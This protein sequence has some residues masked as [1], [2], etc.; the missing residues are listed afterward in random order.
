MDY[1]KIDQN[2]NSL[3]SMS[4]RKFYRK[5]RNKQLCLENK[6]KDN[7][8]DCDYDTSKQELM[9]KD[10]VTKTTSKKLEIIALW[11]INNLINTYL[12]S[13][14]LPYVL[15]D[16]QFKHI[17]IDG[18]LF[19]LNK[20][21]KL[22]T[23]TTDNKET[24]PDINQI[25]FY[26]F[27]DEFDH[28][29]IKGELPES[30]KLLSFG[31][32]FNQPILPDVLPNS[33]N[34]LIFGHSFNQVIEKGTLP[35]NLTHLVFGHCFNQILAKG[36]LPQKLTHLFFGYSFNQEIYH[37]VL[38]NNLIHL[39]F[40]TSFNK[41]LLEG[42]MPDSLVH[43]SFGKCFNQP[44]NKNL[45]PKNLTHL[46]FR[47]NFNQPNAECVFPCNLCTYIIDHRFKLST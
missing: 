20:S 43:L 26:M 8:Y 38:P 21:N 15:F 6:V 41:L 22:L 7:D 33:I 34:H 30:L 3:K 32:K 44:L 47:D 40:G 28:Q 46:V 16:K 14:T 31:W 19:S 24:Q 17:N 37:D 11:N 35:E 29:L 5:K 2:T 45:I 10:S 36:I 13:D 23:T 42:V 1:F 9:N 18:N 4:G 12:F 27:D 39:D 25:T